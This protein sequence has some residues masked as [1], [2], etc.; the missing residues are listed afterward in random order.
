[1]NFTERKKKNQDKNKKEYAK[2]G[3]NGKKSESLKNR[4]VGS[5][6]PKTPN[7]YPETLYLEGLS[8][9]GKTDFVRQQSKSMAK[10]VSNSH[11]DFKDKEFVDWEEADAGTRQAVLANPD[12]YFVFVEPMRAPTALTDHF[13]EK[14][15]NGEPVNAYM[16]IPFYLA[17]RNIDEVMPY[18][19]PD[20]DA[21]KVKVTPAWAKL[22]KAEGGDSHVHSTLFFDEMNRAKD[23]DVL[24][25][26][27]AVFEDQ[28]VRGVPIS[29]NTWF[30][31]AGN[32]D[33]EAADIQEF[34][35]NQVND[36]FDSTYTFEPT[37]DE[38]LEYAKETGHHAY[39]T[40]FFGQ[41]FG[42]DEEFI[43]QYLD[44]QI[45]DDEKWDWSVRER[46]FGSR[47][48][49]S[50]ISEQ[51][52]NDPMFTDENNKPRNP[53]EL[54]DNELDTLKSKLTSSVSTN[55]A[56]AFV[57]F[58]RA[59]GQVADPGQ[60]W[61]Q[62]VVENPDQIQ[63]ETQFAIAQ[64]A[65]DIEEAQTISFSNNGDIDNTLKNG[66]KQDDNRP[67]PTYL[68]GVSGM[69]KTAFVKQQSRET[70]FELAKQN[71]PDKQYVDWELL[72]NQGLVNHEMDKSEQLT[73][74]E[75]EVLKDDVIT[76]PDDYYLFM[77]PVEAPQELKDYAKN[78]DPDNTYLFLPFYLA[79]RH[80][81]E[82]LGYTVPAQ[83]DMR[84]VID[85]DQPW[86]QYLMDSDINATVFF[87]E[88]NRAA[89][90][91][92]LSALKEAIT[93]L[94][95]RGKP[96]SDNVWFAAAGNKKHEAKDITDINDPF[97]R[98]FQVYN[99]EPPAEE[100]V[101]FAKDDHHPFVT[102]FFTTVQS[103]PDKYLDEQKRLEDND[104]EEEKWDNRL[105]NRTFGNR[106]TWTN[107][108]NELLDD[109]LFTTKNEDGETIPKSPAKLDD[110]ALT[111]LETKLASS[112]TED[113]Y[114]AFMAYIESARDVIGSDR[115]G[116]HW[117]EVLQNEQS[118]VSDLVQDNKQH[119]KKRYRKAIDIGYEDNDVQRVLESGMESSYSTPTPALLEEEYEGMMVNDYIYDQSRK[120][121]HQVVANSSDYDQDDFVDFNELVLEYDQLKRNASLDSAKKEKQLEQLESRMDYLVSDE[122]FEDHFF[123]V[124]P[125]LAQAK[126]GEYGE[127]LCDKLKNNKIQNR[128]LYLSFDVAGRY[129]DQV[130]GYKL[131]AQDEDG[132]ELLDVDREW[133]EY[134]LNEEK[135]D[136]DVHATVFFPEI[137]RA[138]HQNVLS[139]LKEVISEHDVRS[140]SISKNTWFAASAAR[141]DKTDLEAD[142][143]DK[144][145]IALNDPFIRRFNVYNFNPSTNEFFQ[146]QVEQNGQN[147]LHPYAD[148]FLNHKIVDRNDS[149]QVETHSHLDLLL[150]Q[151]NDT[152]NDNAHV[153]QDQMT[154]TREN[155]IDASKKLA[156]NPTFYR[157]DG[158]VIP[159]SELND[160][161]THQF[162]ETIA[163]S[164]GM[165][166]KG[167]DE[168]VRPIFENFVND[169]QQLTDEINSDIWRNI[170]D[171]KIDS[172][173]AVEKI[174]GL[175]TS[176]KLN[177]LNHI[178]ARFSELPSP[179]SQEFE[180]GTGE[181]W[182]YFDYISGLCIAISENSNW[183]DAYI[184]R[185]VQEINR[186]NRQYDLVDYIRRIQREY[187][188][189]QSSDIDD[190]WHN[191]MDGISAIQ[192]AI[193]ELEGEA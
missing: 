2:L 104:D 32:K 140:R 4:L 175:S 116:R 66:M 183:D 42:Q 168:T 20:S 150:E 27:Q 18:D 141:A 19:V 120:Q 165:P 82:V 142:N 60:D 33:H 110:E 118:R 55:A 139:G 184:E 53:A 93:E 127:K 68:E 103:A 155:W 1:M 92:V 16:M 45:K 177:T 39:L 178:V 158:S 112:V 180:Q 143:W 131:P 25:A 144:D 174:T 105:I 156:S 138:R 5:K 89:G 185:L 44:E 97:V 62:A 43:D 192:S 163:S 69:G 11:T 87:D 91:N 94:N 117:M 189:N 17:G 135:Q 24:T 73:K 111:V 7:S 148:L 99:F 72:N 65:D 50:R 22:L 64:L 15:E 187:G 188:P 132:F 109:P 81:D 75:V 149:G 36:T 154:F 136:S 171:G 84:D 173:Q 23:Q 134:L 161:Q 59:I 128:Y 79:G 35:N 80:P 34:S 126:G 88:I 8:G 70:A 31:G 162:I 102:S 133:V 28:M 176:Q 146:H 124:N 170:I 85:I 40:M 52:N 46:L 9:M 152:E 41:G 83:S 172:E 67:T 181:A 130:M 114:A 74:Q 71:H 14:K 121:A 145:R 106:A 58:V 122:N 95:A 63:E 157:N 160:S 3:F 77:N 100:W 186:Y 38:W 48:T 113:G 167:G 193:V 86:V 37:R 96:L 57:S 164:V 108:S 123:Y 119:Y 54:S 30:V 78:N 13:L 169:M 10:E 61:T 49:W 191:R 182:D 125:R 129:P 115:T 190:K 159:F 51:L 101:E 76:N 56:C 29:Q 12:D 98:R 151:E 21:N 90:P 166:T 6:N 179:T 47:A 137:N 147:S 26:V 107:I 153:I